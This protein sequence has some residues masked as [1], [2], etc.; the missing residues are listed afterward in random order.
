MLQAVQK[1]DSQ[2]IPKRAAPRPFDGAEDEVL[3]LIGRPP[4]GED[5]GFL[6][7][8]AI[9]PPDIRELAD[10]WRAANDVVND[11]QT[12]EA[13]FA[14]NP[15]LGELSGDVLEARDRLLSDE[16]FRRSMEVVPIDVKMVELDRLVVPQ[17]H[18]NLNNVR[19]IQKELGSFPGPRQIFDICMPLEHPRDSVRCLRASA[20]SFVFASPSH[21]LRF[22]DVFL[23][24][25][26]Q[27]ESE[28]TRGVVASVIGLMVGYSCNC[29]TAMHVQNRLVLING[30]HRALAL[31]EMG[32]THA[33]CVIQTVRRAEELALIGP[34][35]LTR[36][37]SEFLG[38]PRPIVLK[39]FLDPRLHR[40]VRVSRRM[41]QVKVSF[42][43]DNM[44]APVVE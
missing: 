27:I 19:H 25:P 2:S 9:D 3:Y 34:R 21:D 22:L 1:T 38:I 18:I 23:L 24:D 36:N 32:L 10:D 15:T 35:E 29:L 40:K 30:T 37:T 31:R 28:Q 5:L 20:D 26:S 12:R 7:S 17:K 42:S 11:L 39:D 33:P 16:G 14:D 44:D 8:Q 4:M 6:N 43:V 13:G 41:R